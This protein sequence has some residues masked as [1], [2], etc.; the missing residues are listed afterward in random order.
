M[1]RQARRRQ[2]AAIVIWRLDRLGRSLAHLVTLATE[3]HEIGVALVS[4]GEN[5]DGSTSTGRLMLGIMGSLAEFERERLRERTM[6]GLARAKRQGKR[7]GRPAV[8]LDM[9][10]TSVLHLS[11]AKAAPLLGCSVATAGRLLRVARG[12]NSKSG[13]AAA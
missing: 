7:L 13:E 9:P 1:L 2:F 8:T 6:L 11:A 3:L 5:I 10:I 4:L 12:G